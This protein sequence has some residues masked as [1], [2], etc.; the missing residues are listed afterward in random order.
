M[1]LENNNADPGL[2][3]PEIP[4]YR[5]GN[6]GG[7]GSTDVDTSVEDQARALG[8]VPENEYTGKAPWADAD[9]FLEVH[10]RNNGALRKALEKQ[11]QQIAQL[12]KAMQGM[13]ATHKRIFDLQ[14]KKQKEE[15]DQQLAFLKAQKKEALRAGEHETAAD[16]DDQIDTLRERG[17]E[18]PEVP[19]STPASK[20]AVQQDWRQNKI[21]ADWADRN[22]WFEKD[23]DMSAYAGAIGQK[24]RADNPTMPF[25]E[26]LEEVS[27]R[28][29]K[30]FPQKF[31]ARRA[32][33][34]EE[35]TPGATS[36]AATRGTYASLPRDAKQACDEAVADGQLTQKQWVELYYGY[37][38]RRKR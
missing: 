1:P 15:F 28:V 9:E 29:R 14:I 10:G 32:S 21:L 37:E 19:E 35:P 13:D 23:E 6:D 4:E 18:L 26:L 7:G 30:A 20:P 27:G 3:N 38:D 25:T 8:W 11:S 5:A 36:G 16:I 17:P 22:P 33:P 31:T 2:D 24:L 34:V 12:E